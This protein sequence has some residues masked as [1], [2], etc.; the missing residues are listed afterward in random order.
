[1]LRILW[2]YSTCSKSL[3]SGGVDIGSRGGAQ[4]LQWYLCI[5]HPIINELLIPN[6]SIETRCCKV[7]VGLINS[8]THSTRRCRKKLANLWCPKSG[9]EVVVSNKPVS[10][11]LLKF[12]WETLFRGSSGPK[13]CLESFRPCH[14]NM[15]HC[16]IFSLFFLPSVVSRCTLLLLEQQTKLKCTIQHCGGFFSNQ[17]AEKNHSLLRLLLQTL[18]SKK[19]SHRR[20]LPMPSGYYRI[21]VT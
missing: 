10:V 19:L 4:R 9:M 20:I 15:H 7:P 14:A 16:R 17:H 12:V 8:D 6:L 13:R 11:T 5:D 2:F 3:S 18:S 1:M 21:L